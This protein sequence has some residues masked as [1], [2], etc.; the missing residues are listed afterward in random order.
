MLDSGKIY[1]CFIALCVLLLNSVTSCVPDKPKPKLDDPIIAG[2]R[3]FIANEGSLDNGNASLSVYLPDSNKIYNNVFKDVNGIPVGDVLQSINI[4]N[5]QIYIVINN[6]DKILVLD[7]KTYSL[8]QTITVAKPRYILQ[9]NANKAYISSLFHPKIFVL[10]LSSGQIIKEIKTE[11]PNTENI[12]IHN[13]KVYASNWDTACNYIY[14]INSETDEITDKINISGYAPHALSL[15]KNNKLWVLSGNVKKYKKSV[16]TVID[17]SS[18]T[19]AKTITFPEHADA[20]KTA[21]N[22]TKDTL[23]FIG[24]NYDGGTDFNGIYRISIYDN[25]L[26][27][28]AFIQAQAM[29]YFWGLNIDPSNGDIYVGDPKGFI[30]QGNVLIYHAN[31]NL[32]HTI[33]TDIGPS[34]F[35]FEK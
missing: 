13:K 32:Q 3:V 9:V 6:S 20:I 8:K 21:F 35:F 10:D 15:D 18:K 7:S 11:Y 19:V 24:V 33:T 31:G 29:Q 22:P 34:F 23:Y 26:P 16:L 14:E 12:I 28:A 30:Q 1:Y 17:L 5:D 25:Q 2:R 4:I 27:T